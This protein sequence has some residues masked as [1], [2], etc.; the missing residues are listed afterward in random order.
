MSCVS[1]VRTVSFFRYLIMAGAVFL[2]FGDR[3]A[4]SAIILSADA[5][6]GSPP[7]VFTIDP[8]GLG[9]AERGIATN[10]RLRQTFQTSEAFTVG[11]IVLSLNTNGS[12][13]GLIVN[14]FEVEDVNA[15]TFTPGNLLKTLTVPT[16]VDIPDSMSRL[17]LRLTDADAFLLPQRNTG[18]QGYGLEVSNADD[19]TTIGV[20]RHTN[21]GTDEFT[22]GKYYAEDGG[23]SGNGDRDFGVALNPVPEPASLVLAAIAA[24]ALCVRRRRV[25]L[26]TRRGDN[27]R[28]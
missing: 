19:T 20:M 4:C 24:A 3:P 17:G 14:V 28:D 13:G 8:E 23:D 10:R 5:S 15:A 7:T 22:S 2:L 9:T 16:S 27:E 12:D 18:T 1:E 25:S 26:E 21:S 6:Y 11:E